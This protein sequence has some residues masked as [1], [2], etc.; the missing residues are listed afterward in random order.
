MAEKHGIYPKVCLY[1]RDDMDRLLTET[2]FEV[3]SISTAGFG[4]VKAIA[5]KRSLDN[6]TGRMFPIQ[7]L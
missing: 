2:G 1:D 7:I 3:L 5:K 4:N 6:F